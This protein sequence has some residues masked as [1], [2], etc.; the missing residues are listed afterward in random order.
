[1][2]TLTLLCVQVE[3]QTTNI[4][5]RI[6][7]AVNEKNLVVL[8]GNVHPLAR[9]EFD[10]GTVSDGQPLQRILLLLKRS[11]E[12]ETALQKL[13]DDQ[14]DKSSSNYHAWLTP[15]Q[16]GQQFG[17]ADADIQ[18]ITNWLQ[19]QGFQVTN[20]TA[21][22]TVIEFS[23]TAGQVHSAFHTLMHSYSVN[24]ETNMA[25]AS[26]P[27]IPAA[28]APVVAGPVS[29]NNFPV[30]SHLLQLGTF[31]K[32]IKTGETKPLFTFPGCA[33]S[34]YGIGPADFGMIYNTSPLLTGT[35]KIDGTGQTIAIVGES[36]IN[37]QDVIDFR[38]IFGLSQN[39]SSSNIIL[40]GP[41]PGFNDSEGESDLD[42]QWSGAVAP[43]ATIKFVISEPTETTAG[44]DLS[45]IYIIEN[46]LAGV[47]S[48][49]FG[50]C[51]QGLGSARNA[52]YNAMWEQAAAQGITVLISAGDGGS[53]GCDNFD[54][55][56]SA[57]QGLA[58]SGIA[59][60]P[61]NV[62]VGGTDFDQ[63]NNWSQ[64]WSVSNTSMTQASALGYIPEIPWNDSCAQLG[65]TGCASPPQ[66]SLNIVAGSGGVST[67][68]PKPSWQSG[69]G[70][71]LDSHR[72]LPDVS[73]F[74]SNGFDGSFY[75][76]CQIDVTAI[77]G[78]CNLSE[79]EYTFQGAGVT[80]V[81]TPAFAGIMSLVNQKQATA[82][83][84]APRQGNANYV[85]Y[86]LF[87]KQTNTTPALNCNSSATPASVCTF[88]DITR[89]N[90]ALANSSVG[91]NDV[92]CTGGSTNCSIKMAGTNGVL[93]TAVNPST[94]AYSTGTGYD[95]T[96]GLG[97][98]N[99]A[100]LVN[101]W[102]S[103]TFLP[104]TT[105]LSATVNGSS[106]TSIAG[107]THGTPVNVSSSVAAGQGATGTPTGQIALLATP[108]P[109]PGNPGPSL[110][111]DALSLTNGVAT[112][113][114]VI[115]PGGQYNLTAH[116]QGDGTF[117]SSDSTPGISVN[118]S[119][120]PSKTLI[121]IPTFSATTG[122]ETGNSPTSLV[123]ASPYIAR[124]DVGRAQANLSFPP[125]SV[126]TPPACP[127]GTITWMDSYDG[128][129]PAPL[130]GGTF[131][132]NSA[133]FAEDQFIQLP[134]G[135]HVLS[136]SYSG[137]DSFASSSAQGSS[138]PTYSITIT[139]APTTTGPG[140][141]P[142]P[143]QIVLPFGL[144]ATVSS[145]IFGGAM[146]SCNVTF[147]DGN[148]PVP[149]TVQCGGQNGGA[150]YGA[151]I[152]PSLI[153]N[154]TT[155]GT[156]TYTAKFNGDANY[157]P[158]SSAPMTTRVFYGTA[159]SISATATNIQY[160][161]SITLTAIV[162][163]TVPQGG[164]QISNLVTFYFG[165]GPTAVAGTASYMPITDPSGN[166][167][168]QATITV[169]PQ[170][171]GFFTATFTGDNN[172]F[173]GGT[174]NPVNVTVN[175]PDFSLSANLP[176]SSITA[177]SS[178]TATITATP[179]SNA[180]SPVALTCPPLNS[181]GQAQ[182]VG[183]SCSFSPATV[184]LS[185]GVA[186]TSTLTISTLAPSSSNTTSFVP[187]Q[188]PLW[189]SLQ[190]L[191]RP[192]PIAA[193]V[194]WFI[195][196]VL[197]ASRHIHRSAILWASACAFTLVL[198]SYGCGGGASGGV[199]DGGGGEPVPTSITL[200]TPNVKVPFN[201]VSGVVIGL[202]ATVTSSK[203]PGG[204]VTFQVDGTSG[205]SVDSPVVAGVAQTQ[206]TG[207]AVG[208][209]SFSAQYS[210][211][212]NNLSAQTNGTLNVAITGSTGLTLQGSTG[213]LSHSAGVTFN[214][215]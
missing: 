165:Y 159:V 177:G 112:G 54:T 42:V 200:S 76:F 82:Q 89:G 52:F 45:A 142:L 132:L 107:I 130:D 182:P 111:F 207:L 196:L 13:L 10:R 104:S 151:F 105:I 100:N 66:G 80:S 138:S 9:P 1:M 210:G 154:Q 203:P 201:P 14:Q 102:S 87:K 211:D 108:S 25:N 5:A 30:K 121:S 150:T 16:F 98:V 71:P 139:P 208:V 156:H 176:T 57:S 199:G 11:P 101:N 129:P 32:S 148:T 81:S 113:T 146:E 19:S 74:A 65:L 18:A 88:Y 7:E 120:E 191:R 72:D 62:S 166:I 195:L 119:A 56:K 202:S 147:L 128:A 197:A 46:N 49:S 192:L 205:F 36:D 94:P 51:E 153:V 174:I 90:T 163:S 109:T 21:G 213:G 50:Q 41:D 122:R 125:Q 172:Y 178:A 29:L 8:K 4:P 124:I 70:V 20:I 33:G 141:P 103:V 117:G 12:Q 175:I 171:S 17:P 85:L 73:L 38:T 180:S 23:G 145:Q 164:P 61:F 173:N 157:A 206:I 53:A 190:R 162:D 37:P 143:A 212:T 93:V 137:D 48:E 39:F 149:G 187:P 209:H 140:N 170:S 99:A 194:G 115:L 184:N 68:Y 97:S 114:G 91:N 77:G 83:N 134:G 167:A 131:V 160:G 40:D 193:I 58:V 179:A 158:S 186:N 136:A 155:A 110:G 64:Y 214:L 189:Y 84:P 185:T 133:G 67:I 6:T 188:V 69:T 86:Q 215:Q 116:Y 34:C 2:I 161:S 44:I 118:I 43:G 75:I 92:P 79:Y 60:T 35:P 28:L 55:A 26:D 144:G 31:Q 127:T 204:T 96:T 47:M 106:V 15:A 123:Y 24:G 3:A 152:Q 135:N 183:I 126:C 169:T 95:L 63:V 59:S 22:R 181:L 27:Q 78:S 198:G 168:L